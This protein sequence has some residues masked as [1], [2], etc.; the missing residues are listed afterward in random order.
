L[1]LTN[2]LDLIF[3]KLVGIIFDR[4]TLVVYKRQLPKIHTNMIIKTIELDNPI[5]NEDQ[6]SLI[7]SVKLFFSSML[8]VSADIL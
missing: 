6:L 1:A 5:E 4:D 8:F 2:P 7:S 3:V